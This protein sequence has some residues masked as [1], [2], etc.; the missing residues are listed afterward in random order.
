M[1]D[2]NNILYFWKSMTILNACIKKGTTYSYGP[3]H[4]NKQMQDD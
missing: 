1:M 2:N 4:M 3:P